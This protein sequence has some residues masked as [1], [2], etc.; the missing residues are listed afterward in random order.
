MSEDDSTPFSN[1]QWP[2]GSKWAALFSL[3]GFLLELVGS[4]LILITDFV[5][6]LHV[7]VEIWA[8]FEGDE[9]LGF[10]AVSALAGSLHGD[11]LGSDLLESGIIV[12]M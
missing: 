3:L 11:C 12:P 4:L 2:K 5:E 7:L 1:S 9:K 10:L 6:L 8:S